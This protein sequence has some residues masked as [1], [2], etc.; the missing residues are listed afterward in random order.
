MVQQCSELR[1]TIQQ[2]KVVEPGAASED[3]LGQDILSKV[4]QAAAGVLGRSISVGEPFAAA[5]V[6]SLA[7]V[8]LRDDLRRQYDFI[9]YYILTFKIHTVRH[10]FWQPS[11]C[12][13]SSNICKFCMWP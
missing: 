7:A 11:S 9:S 2:E 6:D 3:V 13:F 5:G 4:L 10:I 1:C 12:A 8:E